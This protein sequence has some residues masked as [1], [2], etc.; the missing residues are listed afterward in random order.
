MIVLLDGRVL[1]FGFLA[2]SPGGNGSDGIEA[3]RERKEGTYLGNA[4]VAV[5]VGAFRKSEYHFA[6]GG[7]NVPRLPNRLPFSTLLFPSS[8]LNFSRLI[9]TAFRISGV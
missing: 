5:P 2:L 6:D 8:Q 3:R 1:W 4:C 9:P 7:G